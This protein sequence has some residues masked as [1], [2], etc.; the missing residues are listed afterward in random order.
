MHHLWSYLG[1]AAETRPKSYLP[2]EWC[3]EWTCGS[4]EAPVNVSIYRDPQDQL[5]LLLASLTSCMSC[6]TEFKV[7]HIIVVGNGELTFAKSTSI[8]RPLH[9]VPTGNGVSGM[10]SKASL[11]LSMTSMTVSKKRSSLFSECCVHV[12]RDSRK[13]RSICQSSHGFSSFLC[14]LMML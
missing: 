1:L 5:T 11:P 13:G 10:R 2:I 9:R 6:S 3:S 8:L 12:S 14:W 7:S 4:W